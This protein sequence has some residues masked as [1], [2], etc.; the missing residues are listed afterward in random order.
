MIELVERNLD[1]FFA[2]PFTAYGKDSPYVS[3]MKADLKRF[4]TAGENPLFA[5]DA[6]FTFWTA[7]RDGRPLG[8]IVAHV[9]R[10]SNDRHGWNKAWFGFFDCANDRE[11]ARAL[12]GAAEN[13]ARARGFASLAGNFNLTAMQQAGIMTDGF[14]RE[15][16]TDQIWGAPHLS[17]LLEANGFRRSF[18]MTTFELD[19]SAMDP[20]GLTDP[21]ETEALKAGGFTFAPV[22]R[23]TLADRLEDARSILNVSFT[24]NPMFVPVSR[25]EFDFQAK[26]M[27]WILDKRISAVMQ[28]DGKAVGAVIAIPDLNPLLKAVGS[29]PGLTLPWHYLKYRLNRKRAVIIFQGVLPDYQGMGVNPLMLAHILRE[30]RKAGY[31]T[32]GGTWIAD[33]N[34]ASLRQ[35]EKGGARPLH[36]LHLFSKELA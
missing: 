35:A 24:D 1:S 5:S 27:K 11:A 9:H 32:V 14:D 33:E 8:R 28:K 4:L 20:K 17:A 21:R 16:Y 36:R 31:E 19:I 30:M 10:A 25:E 7:V 29:R 23:A 13:W 6:D 3:P 2:A 15:P 22:T 12:L 26:D 34:K 18:P